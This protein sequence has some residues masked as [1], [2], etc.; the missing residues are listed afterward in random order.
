[1]PRQ[2][3]DK[4]EK[5]M[6]IGDKVYCKKG[7]RMRGEGSF[8]GVIVGFSKWRNYDAVNVKKDFP[9]TTY[10]ATVQCLVKNIE[11]RG[12]GTSH[13]NTQAKTVAV[14]KRFLL[15]DRHRIGHA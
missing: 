10:S 11:V 12:R 13:N 3:K 4:K 6:K 15:S 7:G 5:D 1:M 9:R 8:S 2:D 14:N